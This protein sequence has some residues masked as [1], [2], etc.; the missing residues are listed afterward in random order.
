MHKSIVLCDDIASNYLQEIDNFLKEWESHSQTIT[1]AT[2]GSTGVPKQ[3]L[4]DKTKVR[5]SAHATGKFFNFKKGQTLLLNLSPNYIAGK[6]MLVR[7]L[8]HDMRILVAPASENPLLGLGNIQV[9]FAAFVPYQVAAILKNAETKAAYEKITQVII[10]GATIPSNVEA[11]L[12]LLKNESY[13]TFGMTETITHIALRSITSGDG[14]YKC[15]PDITIAQ[16]ERG[17][18]V[19]NESEI[20]TRLITND[21]IT[22]IDSQKFR[23]QGRLDNVVNSAG[24]KLFPEELE[25]KIEDL[26]PDIRFYFLGRKSA[27][28]GE[29]LVLYIEGDQATSWAGIQV[30]IDQRLSKFERPKEVFFVSQF[31]ET[32]TGKVI[33]TN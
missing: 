7:A 27:V 26:F 25:K 4:L 30:E 21:L 8:E 1:V 33:R 12:R 32:A 16:D 6:L 20:S 18:L 15:L 23:W 14:V 2:S 10:G 11:E 28:F 22:Q 29:E 5:A 31:K 17:C 24:I 13:A 9:D 19:I 3:F